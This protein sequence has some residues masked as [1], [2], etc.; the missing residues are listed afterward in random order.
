MKPDPISEATITS[1]KRPAWRGPGSG[2]DAWI[3]YASALEDANHVAFGMVDK[4]SAIIIELQ[5]EIE[6]LRG[7]IASRKPKGGRPR[8]D[9]KTAA[10]IEAALAGGMSQRKAA[11]LCGVSAMTVSRVAARVAAR[12][13]VK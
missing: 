9:D 5:A 8:T 4:Q 6:L 11:R 2:K 3:G 13:A 10:R 12:G 1:M 7:Q